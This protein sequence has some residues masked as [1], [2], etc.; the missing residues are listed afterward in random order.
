MPHWF[1]DPFGIGVD[2]DTVRTLSPME[3]SGKF[4]GCSMVTLTVIVPGSPAWEMTMIYNDKDTRDKILQV[5][6]ERL[7]AL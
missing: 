4:D 1:F 7:L 6:R 3:G 5:M 2:L